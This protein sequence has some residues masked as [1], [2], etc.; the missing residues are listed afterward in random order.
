MQFNEKLLK[1]LG[2]MLERYNELETLLS[3][4]EVISDNARYTSYVKEHGRLSKFVGKYSQLDE[5]LKQ[6]EEARAI[7]SENNGDKDLHNLARDE[8]NNLEKKEAQ[9]FEEIKGYFFTEGDK[10]HKNVIMEI[11][12]GTGGEE[13]AL[14]VAD[15][16]RMYTKYAE[17]QKWKV[18]MLASSRTEMG[19]FKEITFS[20]SGEK[21]YQKLCY[22]SGAHRVQRVPATETSGRIHTSAATVA[23]LPEIEEVEIKID[24]KDIEVDTFRSSGPGGQKVNKTS[25]AV[26]ITHIPTGLVVKCMDEKSQ[27]RNRDKAMRILRSR[28]YSFLQ[29][30]K[31]TERDKTRRTQIGSGDRSEKIR[32]YNY[33]QN[34]VTDHRIGLNLYSLDR[35][36]LGEMDELTEAMINHGKEEKMKELAATL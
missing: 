22:E 34:R 20:V 8:V 35:I 9:L 32:T 30:Q 26:R 5:T 2:E 16:F 21:V 19:G 14:F 11:R 24:P 4:P 33:P 28:L 36:M 18:E 27:H 15:L 29:D 23:V 10:S 3:D 1:K 25:S 7:L 12:A 6:K 17:K 31:K 13:A